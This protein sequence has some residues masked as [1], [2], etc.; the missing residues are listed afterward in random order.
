MLTNRDSQCRALADLGKVIAS[1]FAFEMKQAYMDVVMKDRDAWNFHE[2]AAKG[3]D[4]IAD[5]LADGAGEDKEETAAADF[6]RAFWVPVLS[7]RWR[8][9]R[10][11]PFTRVRRGW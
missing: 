9:I 7:I 3:A 2:R 8:P 11:S 5:W 10:L 1:A 4:M 6:A